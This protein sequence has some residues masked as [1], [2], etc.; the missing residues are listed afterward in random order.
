VRQWIAWFD[1]HFWSKWRLEPGGELNGTAVGAPLSELRERAEREQIEYEAW[2]RRQEMGQYI[3]VSDAARIGGGAARALALL[4][5]EQ[6]EQ[7]RVEAFFE[8]M[9]S[10]G[11]ARETALRLKE[12]LA[13]LLR[14]VTESVEAS[15]A[16]KAEE[17][18][19]LMRKEAEGMKS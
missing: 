4:W 9:L 14:G 16:A 3:L 1:K 18:A 19:G 10:A 6:L 2:Q 5:R 11:V 13:S 7:V 12:S 8:E 17:F 15:A